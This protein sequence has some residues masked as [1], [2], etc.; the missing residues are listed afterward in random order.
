MD[1]ETQS[2]LREEL[3]QLRT[4]HRELD[5]EIEAAQT[6]GSVNFLRLQ[7]LKKEKLWLRDRIQQVVSD[8]I[9]DII[10]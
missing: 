6:G 3:E 7:Q 10:A 4:R 9:P 1:D 2:A 8:L 5:E